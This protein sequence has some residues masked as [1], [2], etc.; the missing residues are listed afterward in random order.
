MLRTKEMKK[1]ENEI[2]KKQI[3]EIDT[4]I[5]YHRLQIKKL[6]DKKKLINNS[7]I[8]NLDKPWK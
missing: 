8:Y 4:E 6:R 7:Y 5:E 2:K 3:K 1:K